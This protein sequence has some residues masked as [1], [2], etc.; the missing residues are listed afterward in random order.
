MRGHR[1][2][3]FHL[4]D[5]EPK[6]RAEGLNFLPLKSSSIQA[7][8]M[9]GALTELSGKS[10]IDAMRFTV[11]CARK[12]A[13]L[14]CEAA[15][16]AL[17]RAG[18]D[19]LLVDQNEP[20]A[21]TVAE[22]LRLPFVSV[23]GGLPLNREPRLPPP[24]VP[25]SYRDSLVAEWRNRVAYA[26]FDRLLAPVNRSL[27]IRRKQWGLPPVDKPDDTFSPLAQICQMAE[28]FDFPRRQKPAALAYVGLLREESDG[29]SE[30]PWHRLDG[31]PFVYASFGTLQNGVEQRFRRIAEAAVQSQFQLVIGLGG[32]LALNA[33]DLPGS[34]IVMSFAPQ[35]PLLRRAAAFITHGGLNSVM[36]SLSCGTPMIVLPVTNDQPAVA[37]RVRWTGTGIT[38]PPA[39]LNE[40]RIAAALRL[41]VSD[42]SFRDNARRLQQEFSSSGGPSAAVRIVEDAITSAQRRHRPFKTPT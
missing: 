41:L 24:F 26:A 11:E 7:G 22:H 37:A 30:F 3:A 18:V 17:Q 38:I 12:T 33:G 6:I 13:E 32:R 8:D 2:T 29:D 39:R 28:S 9:A 25:W 42:R 35:R 36:E 10:G 31:R 5:A 20:A 40:Q 23:C 14:I 1:V 21:A 15:P 34:P 4:P 16:E 19:A 27:N